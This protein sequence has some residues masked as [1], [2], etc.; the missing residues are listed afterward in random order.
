MQQLCYDII[1]S[2]M[3]LKRIFNIQK[4]TNSL[5]I[6]QTGLHQVKHINEVICADCFILLEPA[7]IPE[8]FSSS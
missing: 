8:V 7:Q 1:I 3:F 6:F 2:Y 4:F 5:F